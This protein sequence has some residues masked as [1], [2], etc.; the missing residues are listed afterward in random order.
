MNGHGLTQILD[1]VEL[2]ALATWLEDDDLQSLF[3][4]ES[5]ASS[6]FTCYQTGE[7]GTS[8]FSGEVSSGS[9]RQRRRPIYRPA[10]DAMWKRGPQRQRREM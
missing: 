6:N 3:R 1:C 2:A 4:P 5:I 9:V 7:Q 8:R 10:T